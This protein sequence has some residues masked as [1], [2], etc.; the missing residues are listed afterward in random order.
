M[1]TFKIVYESRSKE[2]IIQFEKNSI[3][4]HSN[5]TNS[6][7]GGEYFTFTSDVIEKLKEH[8]KGKNNPCYGRKWSIDEKNKLRQSKKNRQETIINGIKYDSINQAAKILHIRF[9]NARK[10]ATK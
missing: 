10:L 4:T 7:T 2:K 5:L 3:L 1:P 9:Y 6:T 8:N